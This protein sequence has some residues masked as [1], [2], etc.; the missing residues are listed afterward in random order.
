MHLRS[1][2]AATLLFASAHAQAKPAAI[3]VIEA[4]HGGAGQD[5]T[6]QTITIPLTATYSNN[7]A[8][9]EVS[10]LY[11]VSA[12]G[13]P[14]TSISCTPFRHADG[15]GKSGLTFDSTTPSFLS[16]NTVQVGSIVCISSDI[17]LAPPPPGGSSAAAASSSSILST[18]MKT[19][20]PRVETTTATTKTHTRSAHSH[21][22]ATA[23]STSTHATGSGST[24]STTPS[25]PESTGNGA[26]SLGL[27]GELFG[28]LALAG[29]GLA[30]AL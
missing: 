23:Q 1:L 16:T 21:T 18:G 19:S 11:L 3:V 15:T 20:T 22:T 9:A 12:V 7:S 26:S 8:L 24:S 28:G 29:F 5:L 27:S 4:S 17:S 13:V 10:T 2:L 6:N 14:V 30:F 25:A